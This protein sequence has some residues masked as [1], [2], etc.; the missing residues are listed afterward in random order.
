MAYHATLDLEG[1]KFDVISSE[2]RIERSVDGKG[3]PSSNLYSGIITIQVESNDDT[4]IFERMATQY[5][6]NEG[7]ITFMKDEVDMMKELKWKNGYIVG[8]DE[9]MR[10]TDGSPMTISFVISA[11]TVIVGGET[12]TQNWPEK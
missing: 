11:Q 1:N 6:P 8:F 3:R 4:M 12:L 5:T 10:N 7:T 9:C 2:C